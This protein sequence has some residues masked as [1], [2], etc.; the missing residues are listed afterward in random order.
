[1]QNQ[2]FCVAHPNKAWI[3]GCEKKP[4]FGA[5]EKLG[6]EKPCFRKE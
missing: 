4:G 3:G 6:E 2:R 1:M 5:K